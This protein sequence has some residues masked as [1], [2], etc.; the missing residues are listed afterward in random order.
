M[1][2][3]IALLLGKIDHAGKEWNALSE[4][5]ELRQ[6][7]SGNREQ[8]IADFKAGKHDGVVAIYRT[9]DSVNITGR[10]D[11][12]LIESLPTTLRSI[13]H[14][15][16]GYDQIDVSACTARSI[17]V[18]NTP[19]A[20]DAA[21]ADVAMMLLLGALR[22]SWIPESS[23]RAGNWRGNMQLGHDPEGKVLGILGMGGIGSALAKRAK[24]FEMRVVYHNRRR[25]DEGREDRAKYVGF[26]ELLRTSDV[27]SVH[28]PLS[29]ATKGIVGKKEFEMMKNGVVLINTARGAI[30]DE[31]ALVE[32]LRV[33]KVFS[34]GLDV[35]GNEPEVHPELVRNENVV[36]L[37]HIGTATFETQYK[38]EVLVVR[39]VRNSIENGELVTPVPEQART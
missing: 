20:V 11:T 10:F 31:E 17:S 8:V 9:F 25:L 32:A 29:Q 38:M 23:L 39:N 22:R 26:E 5:A 3:P 33:G 35:Y 2:K 4:I 34:A 15:G 24:A 13:S 19:V 37:P 18:S 1:S 27:I 21:T 16:A 6:I 28:L 12:P 36:L 30:V 14:N 7:S